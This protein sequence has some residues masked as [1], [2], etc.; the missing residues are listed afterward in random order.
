M[1][2]RHAVL[3][4]QEGDE[5]LQRRLQRRTRHLHRVAAEHLRQ[6][7]AQLLAGAG[8]VRRH[9]LRQERQQAVEA[10]HLVVRGEHLARTRPHKRLGVAQQRQRNGHKLRA[11]HPAAGTHALEHLRHHRAGDGRDLLVRVRETLLQGRDEVVADVR[12]Q[13]PRHNLHQLLERRLALAPAA[14]RHAVEQRAVQQR[15]DVLRGVEAAAAPAAAAA[16]AARPLRHTL[17]DNGTHPLRLLALVLDLLQQCGAQVRGLNNPEDR[18]RPAAPGERAE[19]LEGAAL[20]GGRRHVEALQGERRHRLLVDHAAAELEHD[21]AEPVEALLQRLRALRAV[22]HLQRGGDRDARRR[23]LAE[24]QQQL[25]QRPLDLRVLQLLHHR[26]HR[27]HHPRRHHARAV[28]HHAQHLHHALHDLEVRVLPPWH[29]S[30]EQRRR[31]LDRRRALGRRLREGRADVRRGLQPLLPRLRR[32]ALHDACGLRRQRRLQHRLDIGAA[33]RRRRALLRRSLCGAAAA[34]AG[35]LGGLR[36]RASGG[37]AAEGGAAAGGAGALERPLVGV[38]VEGGG[39]RVHGGVQGAGGR[40]AGG[41]HELAASGTRGCVAGGNGLQHL[42]VRLGVQVVEEAAAGLA[43]LLVQR[44]ADA[45]RGVLHAGVDVRLQH[46]HGRRGEELE[47]LLGPLGGVHHAALHP[48]QRAEADQQHLVAARLHDL[49]GD[50]VEVQDAVLED[51]KEDVAQRLGHRDLLLLLQREEEGKEDACLAGE[52]RA[53]SLAEGQE[54]LARERHHR[55]V[56]VRQRLLQGRGQLLVVVGLQADLRDVRRQVVVHHRL[57]HRPLRL[58]IRDHCVEVLRQV[59][60]H[61]LGRRAVVHH[62]VH[63]LATHRASAAARAARCR[64]LRRLG[65]ADGAGG[66]REPGQVFARLGQLGHRGRLHTL[67]LQER[68]DRRAHRLVQRRHHR[69]RR[70]TH[71]RVGLPEKA[72]E[73]GQTLLGVEDTTAEGGEELLERRRQTL[74]VLRRTRLRRGLLETL[75]DDGG[76]SALHAQRDDLLADGDGLGPAAQPALHHAEQEVVDGCGLVGLDVRL[77]RF[78]GGLQRRGVR[79]LHTLLQVADEGSG[80]SGVLRE[81]VL[82]LLKSTL[83]RL[84]RRV[85]QACLEGTREGLLHRAGRHAGRQHRGL[86]GGRVPGRV[87]A[88]VAHPVA[89]PG[90]D[91]NVFHGMFRAPGQAAAPRRTCNE[92]QIL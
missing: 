32:Q 16:A 1:L 8:H 23:R 65:A 52:A 25:P 41:A 30:V 82:Q 9:R 13:L 27:T 88:D 73:H 36:R 79:V 75:D 6:E 2:A 38:V 70:L 74:L 37:G 24:L 64:R 90:V 40:D 56:R 59:L 67:A 61:R 49:V 89:L 17:R 57:L 60:Q 63:G 22:Q 50:V 46:L 7:L 87:H 45:A 18:G 33:V 26:P 55:D 31:D 3:V 21:V 62:R 35:R 34:A 15:P 11:V 5:R 85:R 48:L 72:D 69:A 83:A 43:A 76:V 80:R 39:G 47:G 19:E 78:E 4:L 29:R 81:H 58:R 51:G 42:V 28:R 14:A 20:D 92:V 86:V 54:R 44:D 66:R 68:D 84:P 53:K 71:L 10:A 12:P 91:G 77:R